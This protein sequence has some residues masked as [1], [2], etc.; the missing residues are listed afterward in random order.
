MDGPRTLA[1][2]RHKLFLWSSRLL[3]AICPTQA[4]PAD[5]VFHS[6][7]ETVKQGL[8][9]GPNQCSLDPNF[10]Q[11]CRVNFSALLVYYRGPGD[12]KATRIWRRSLPNAE[13]QK[14]A[15]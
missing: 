2:G 1:G 7:I 11:P 5:L 8:I 12:L 4:N 15:A 3:A 13:N 6:S 10:T 9:K 14:R